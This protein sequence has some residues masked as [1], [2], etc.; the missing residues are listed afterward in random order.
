MWQLWLIIFIILLLTFYFHPNSS[1]FFFL[2]TSFFTLLMALF[3]DN[4]ILT[5]FFFALLYVF[6]H[7]IHFIFRNKSFHKSSLLK[8]FINQKGVVL[9]APKTGLLETGIIYIH[10][11]F[12]I[13]SSNLPL[14]KGQI[15][16]VVDLQGIRLIVAP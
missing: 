1:L 2:L 9:K 11:E 13:I 6:Y 4:L 12:W 5:T 3:I 8:T 7:C 16:K 15:V 14:H 10:H